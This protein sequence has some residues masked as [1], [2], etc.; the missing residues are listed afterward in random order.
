MKLIICVDKNKGMLLF[1]KRQS[2]DAAL[3]KWIIEYIDGAKIWMNEY[4]SDL[5]EN[6]E[7]LF[8][9]E[10]YLTKAQVGDFCFVEQEICSVFD[11][12]EI[13]LCNW[14]RKYPADVVFDFD[15]KKCGFNKIF[16]EDIVGNSHEKITI[17]RFVRR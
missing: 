11:V 14:N 4:S 12:E 9:D 6:A 17:E 15:L 10:S 5:F 8:V 2:R 3:C 7:N 13:L 1:G 16:A